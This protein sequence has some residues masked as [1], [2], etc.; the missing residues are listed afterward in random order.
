M[1]AL[2]EP[3]AMISIL[4]HQTY[5]RLFA[6]QGL[7]LIGTG[8]M[9]VALALLAYDLAGGSAGA[10]LGTMLLLKMVAYVGFAPFAAALAQRL[11]VKPLLVGLDLARVGLVA[12]LPFVEAVWQIYLLV[13]VL[14]LC[15]AA[16]TPAFQSLIPD[17]LPDE[18]DYTRALSL[19]RLAYDLEALAS[20]LLAGLLLTVLGGGDLFLGTALGFAASAALV[21]SAKLPERTRALAPEPFA[22]RLTRGFA[23]YAATPRL[24][25]LFALGLAVAFSGAWVLVNSVVWAQDALGGGAHSYTTL[26][27]AYGAGSMVVALGLPKLLDRL[28]PRFVMGAGGLALGLAPWA[29]LTGPGL[30]GSL[31]LWA[32]LG[33]ATA[34]VLTPTG[35][36]LRRSA[37]AADRPALFAAQFSLSHAGWLVAY[38]LA[39]WLGVALGLA[40]SFA[41]MGGLALAAAL[42]GWALWPADDPLERFHQHA[43][44]DHEHLHVHDA[45]H[46][47]DHEGWEGPEPHRHPHRHASGGH[48]HV[49]VIDDHHPQWSM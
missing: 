31:A 20:P 19:S 13:F 32:L 18:R 38:P 11:P 41:V 27:A 46:Q 39:G 3:G 8:L 2:S 16:F 5:R 48:R 36:L 10:V 1:G 45:H 43:A 4:K 44:F 22:A 28:Q 42:A 47:H 17:V 37:Q 34:L 29:L 21:I 26:P 35:L 25:A 15:S 40:P 14:Q 12:L 24:R 33:A 7:S 6:A 30:A 9:T 23:L 49:F